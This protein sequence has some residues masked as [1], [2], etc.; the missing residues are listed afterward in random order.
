MGRSAFVTVALDL[1]WLVQSLFLILLVARVTPRV[2]S[3]LA[4]PL[5]FPRTLSMLYQAAERAASC[6]RAAVQ[7]GGRAAGAQVSLS[8]SVDRSRQLTILCSAILCTS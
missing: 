2:W 5:D 6:Q 3:I 7:R 8:G 1:P 4:N